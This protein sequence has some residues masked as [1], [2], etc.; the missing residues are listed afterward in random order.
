MGVRLRRDNREPPAKPL[1]PPSPA[2]GVL[3][4]AIGAVA[5][6]ARIPY[7][8]CRNPK[9][10]EP[11]SMKFAVA[12]AAVL[13]AAGSPAWAT[14][15]QPEKATLP[16][17]STHIA[18]P[19]D[20]APERYEITIKPNAEALNFAGRERIALVVKRPT[21]RIVLNAADIAFQKAFL[22]ELPRTPA[23]PGMEASHAVRAWTPSITLDKDQQTVAF[24]FDQPLAPGRYMLAL[25]YTGSIYQQASGLFALD[26]TEA[27]GGKKRA[28]FT[29]FENSDARRLI[30]SWD[31]PG[32]KAIFSLTVEAPA[33]QMA[34][35][36]MP[37]AQQTITQE[38]TGDWQTTRFADTPKMSSYL[39]FLALGD[40]ERVHRQVGA[41]DVGVV[42]RRGD[43]AKAQ[44]ALDAAAELL[45]YYNDYFGTPYPLPKLD[46][47]AGPGRSQ[48]FAAMENWG[49]IYY[50]DYALLVDPQLTTEA[51]KQSIYVDVAHEMA[52]QWFGDL[53]TMAW[54]DDLWLNEGFASWMENKATDHFHPEWKIWL[55]TKV[56]EQAAMR[57]DA[58]SGAHSVIAPIRDVFAAANAF[59]GIT[60]EK[61]HSV[62]HML[63]TYV[64]ED[65]FRTGVRNYIAHHAYGN[66]VT[67]DLWN[68]IDRV[69][70]RKITGIA[71]DFTLQPGVPLISI[72]ETRAG[73]QLTQS[74]YGVDEISKAPRTWQTP[75]TVTGLKDPWRAV[76]SDK[77]PV[78]RAA[79]AGATPLLNAGQAGYFRSRYSTEL[80]A[81]VAAAFPRLHPEDQLGLIYD[82]L[83]LGQAGYAPMSEFLAIA[84]SAEDAQDSI[85]LKATAQQLAAVDDLYRD[86]PGQAAYRAF[87][88]ARLAPAF[89]R[90]GW[91]PKAGEADN[92]TLLRSTLLTTLGQLDDPAVIAEAQRRFA[93]SL[94][95]PGALTGTTRQIVLRIVATHADIATWDQL[96]ALARSATDPTDKTRLYRYLGA[97]LDPALA[98]RALAL[99]LTREPPATDAP[100]II[101]SV[102]GYFPD[103]AFDFAVSHRAQVEAMLEPT[104]RTRFFT[105]L[106]SGSRDPAM[107]AKLTTF[108]ATV[109]SSTRGEVARA[110]AAISYRLDVTAKRLPEVDRWLATQAG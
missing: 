72:A 30:P 24:V 78:S 22:T 20:V 82:S 96:H 107:A 37:V 84:R 101:A 81:R 70:P 105:D 52:H 67:D 40:F 39:L 61:G 42:V 19:S 102:A 69:S 29:Q 23:G 60:Y 109:P 59:D 99:A 31:E 76:V 32:V 56:G 73:F 35:S 48:F 91:D 5:E 103:R 97:S 27:G 86:Q 110:L 18:L 6:R 106:G 50:F 83:A 89:S 71:H 88:R 66:T 47:I 7:L 87:A 46:F 33:G 1:N 11:L 80:A 62:I 63:E 8:A 93:A 26:Y 79:P 10:F 25:A 9:L 53:V 12:V 44:F 90:L 41:T 3:A 65:V 68:E 85:V 64:G 54:W 2:R 34:V 13:L 98:E 16:A 21:D 58:R 104:S 74:R 108:A 94:A 57:T 15:A 45:P 55:Q 75:V 36:N 49:A 38:R 28:L 14:P 95:A 43:T 51:D 92:D 4:E 17:G 77:A 100:E